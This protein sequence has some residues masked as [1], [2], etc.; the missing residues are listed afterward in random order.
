MITSPQCLFLPKAKHLGERKRQGEK[1]AGRG[2]VGC[3]VLCWVR[4]PQGFVSGVNA[5]SLP[6]SRVMHFSSLVH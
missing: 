2:K 5:V 4:V 3:A 1:K 6:F